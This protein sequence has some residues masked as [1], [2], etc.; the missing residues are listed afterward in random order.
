MCSHQGCLAAIQS[1]VEELYRPVLIAYDGASNMKG[2]VSGVSVQ[3]LQEE[4]RA[5]Y[6]HCY[7]H[8]L[9]LACQDTLQDVQIVKDALDTTFEL[10]KLLKYSSK[11]KATF[12]AIKEQL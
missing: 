1:D 4:S 7:D 12:K 5:V 2:H 11:R 3:I 10:S 8:S 9:N 6:T